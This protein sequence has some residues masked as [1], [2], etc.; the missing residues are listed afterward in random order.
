M[1]KEVKL[2][3]TELGNPLSHRDLHV[4]RKHLPLEVLEKNKA[5]RFWEDQHRHLFGILLLRKGLND[6]GYGP[7]VLNKLKKGPYGK[8]YLGKG[9][10]FNISHSGKFIVCAIGKYVK[11]GVDIEEEKDVDFSDFSFVMNDSEWD[12]IY[13]SES[14]RAKF[15]EFWTLKESVLKAEGQG[16]SG[17][18]QQFSIESQKVKYHG[19]YWHL[20]RLCHFK[21]MA[22][23]LASSDPCKVTLAP[24]Y[25]Q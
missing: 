4:Y 12:S 5:F 23:C 24:T 16:L 14:P 25:F 22:C 15:F 3:Y 8:P 6:H 19:N 17:D 9:I 7:G 10:D 11:L 2:Y 21:N 1:I 20:S 13:Q 18:L